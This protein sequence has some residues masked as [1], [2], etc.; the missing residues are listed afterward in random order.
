VQVGL[1]RFVLVDDGP[2]VVDDLAG[3]VIEH[4]NG[5]F[6]LLDLS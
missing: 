4:Y 1:I 3:D 2:E 5:A 6:S